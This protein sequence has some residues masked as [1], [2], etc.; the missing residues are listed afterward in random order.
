M[1]AKTAEVKQLRARKALADQ[2]ELALGR[3]DGL[4]DLGDGADGEDVLFFNF[5][6]NGMCERKEK[7][8]GV[9]CL[10]N[11][12]GRDGGGRVAPPEKEIGVIL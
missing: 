3:F 10:R 6:V 9:R 2:T 7:N 12:G 8:E 11:A 4:G 5:A 1:V